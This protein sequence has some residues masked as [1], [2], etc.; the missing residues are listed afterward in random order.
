MHSRQTEDSHVPST[1]AFLIK[2][3][4][5]Q[6]VGKVAKELVLQFNLNAK[7]TVQELADVVVVYQHRQQKLQLTHFRTIKVTGKD[8]CI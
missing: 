6:G 3:D 5:L 2:N 8:K 7:N 1:A 4:G